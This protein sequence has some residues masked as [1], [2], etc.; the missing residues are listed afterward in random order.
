MNRLKGAYG[1]DSSS[2]SSDDEETTKPSDEATLHFKKPAQTK[3]ITALVAA[4][5]VQPNE[6]MDDRRHLDPSTKELAYN[7]RF[8]ELYAPVAGPANPKKSQQQQAEKNM[9][10]GYVEPAHFNAFQ[11]ELER[12]TFHSYGFAH[13]PSQ[14]SDGQKMINNLVEGGDAS[15]EVASGEAKTV[16]EDVKPRPKDKR[17]R[18]KNTDPSDIEGYL[19]PWGKFKDEQT[20][21]KP[22]EEDAAYLEDYLSK[23]KKRAKKTVDDSPVEEK[24]TLHIKDAYDYQGRSFL[25]IPQDVG[26]NLKS[27]VPPTKCFIPKRQIHEWKG[28]TKGVAVIRWFPVSGHLLLSGAMDTKVKLWEVYKNR[29]CIRTY[30]GHKQAIRDVNFNNK[31]DHFLSTSYDRYIKLWDTGNLT[32]KLTFGPK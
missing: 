10:S 14:N 28:H 20:V 18:E 2:D 1:S 11:F 31:G 23:M 7:P 29:R 4:P 6:S 19:G 21:A 30:S 26:V 25:H 5:T 3:G 9:I 16:F 17:K 22:T 8:D 13:D 24:S 15:E 12:R 32:G 27:D